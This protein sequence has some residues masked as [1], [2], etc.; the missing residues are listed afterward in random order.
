MKKFTQIGM[1]IMTTLF[2]SSVAFSQFNPTSADLGVGMTYTSAELTNITPVTPSDSKGMLYNNGPLVTHPG[3][4]PGGSDYSLL[5]APNT[6]WGFGVQVASGNRLADDFDVPA[7]GWDIDSIIVFAYQ[8]FSTTTST[9]TAVNMRIWDGE[10]GA[11]GA[12]VIWGDVATNIMTDT[13][14]SNCYR[15]S[16]LTNTDRPVM[17]NVCTTTGLSLDEGTYWVDWQLDGTLT[18]GPW[19]PPITIPGQPETGNGIQ[20]TTTG[21]AW[22]PA[23]DNGSGLQQGLPF[24]I[25]GPSA[26]V[27]N[28][29]TNLAATVDEQ[30]VH[31]TWDPPASNI[32]ELI[33]DD[34]T[35]SGSY[36][37]VG[38]TMSSQ[39]SPAGPCKILALKYYT[40]VTDPAVAGF[41]PRVFNWAGTQPGTTI[42]YETT[43]DAVDG[44]WMEVDISAQN[45]NVTDDFMVGFGSFQ[46]GVYMGYNTTD[47]GRAWDY[48]AASAT[49]ASW[50][51]T[52]FIR[53]IVEYSKGDI[54]EL[55]PVNASPK[56]NIAPEKMVEHSRGVSVQHSNPPTPSFGSRALLGYN[57]YRDVTKV[58]SSL[59]TDLFYDD[60]DVDP[61]TYD[62]TVTAVY[63]E[64][65]SVPAGPVEVTIYGV[66][67]NELGRQAIQVYPNPA[68]ST[69]N[70]TSDL[71]IRSIEVLS[72]SGQTIFNNQNVNARI[73]RVNVSGLVDGV[74]FM[75]VTTTQDIRTVK[76]IVTR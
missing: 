32:E 59:I 41:E 38:Y 46:D 1:M 2:M 6:T 14:W 57:A 22:A 9:F 37:Y 7:G 15:G 48:E 21:G 75:R 51:E 24:E 74:Y 16:T 39:M 28:P 30:D 45:I 43:A 12:T 10:P 19:G 68:S 60:L 49:W 52:Y 5:E 44:D 17:R 63:D 25:W 23:L 73:S 33:Y 13:Y 65:E 20:Y 72:Y 8:S 35:P 66:S 27:L 42:L 71:D 56:T 29:P 26:A 76:I 62:Y 34:D 4:G 53:A 36:S 58:N 55:L 67:I 61:G 64:G 54:V 69:V 3:G 18:S 31:L 47:N 40:T 70:V 11:T 50:N